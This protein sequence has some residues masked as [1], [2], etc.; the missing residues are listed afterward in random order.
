M[1]VGVGLDELDAAA[2]AVHVAEA[3]D[4]HEDVELEALA[5]GEGAG[6]LVVAAAVFGAEG[7]YLD[8]KSVV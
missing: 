1:R 2:M 3:A 7:D 4:V 6:E 8:R 5:G